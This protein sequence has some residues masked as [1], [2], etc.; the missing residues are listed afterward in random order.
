MTQISY[1]MN[2]AFTYFS[3]FKLNFYSVEIIKN[4]NEIYFLKSFQK[5]NKNLGNLKII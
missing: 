1:S 3:H 2:Y 5:K 4:S